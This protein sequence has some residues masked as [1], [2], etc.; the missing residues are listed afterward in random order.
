MNRLFHLDCSLRDG[1]YYNNWDFSEIFINNYLQV[2][3]SINVD[4]CEIGFRFAKN[5]G[6]RGSCAFTSEEFI[7]SLK[8]PKKLK[9]AI[10]LNGNDFIDDNEFKLDILKRIIPVKSENSKVDLIRVAC[11]Y[12]SIKNVLPLFDYLDDYS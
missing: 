8:I 1:G 7:N 3:E 10:M 9:L 4:F 11:H 2:L 12:E 5:T 6:F